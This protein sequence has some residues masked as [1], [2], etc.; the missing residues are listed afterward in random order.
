M[1]DRAAL[2]ETVA[3]DILYGQGRHVGHAWLQGLY[4][5][6]VR[7]LLEAT[8]RAADIARKQAPSRAALNAALAALAPPRP[9]I[10][11]VP[12]GGI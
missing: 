7:D 12:A 3:L 4:G 9:L 6:P 5:L 10:T 11:R 8:K 2:I 1:T